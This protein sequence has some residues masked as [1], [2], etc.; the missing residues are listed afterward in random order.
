MHLYY[1]QNKQC[2]TTCEFLS[3]HIESIY[4]F[5]FLLSEN[6]RNSFGKRAGIFL[7]Q[8]VTTV[9]HA[10]GLS[11]KAHL[12]YFHFNNCLKWLSLQ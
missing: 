9:D 6:T 12:E 1:M 7:L 5:L 4:P 2:N 8:F 10:H 11:L 3:I